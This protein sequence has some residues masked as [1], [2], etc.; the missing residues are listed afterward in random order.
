MIPNS[1]KYLKSNTV[2]IN[3]LL[4]NRILYT[5][6]KQNLTDHLKKKWKNVPMGHGWLPPLLAKVNRY[7]SV[8]WYNAKPEKAVKSEIKLGLPFMVLDIVYVY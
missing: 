4:V 3:H 8:K 5:N 1:H 7:F 2:R 6:C